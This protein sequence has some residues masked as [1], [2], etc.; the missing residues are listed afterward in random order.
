MKKS[1]IAPEIK[2]MSVDNVVMAATSGPGLS[3]TP[4]G[5]LTSARN[6]SKSGGIRKGATTFGIASPPTPLQKRG[7]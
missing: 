4:A 7:E 3:D 1:Y 6:N 2:T 5:S